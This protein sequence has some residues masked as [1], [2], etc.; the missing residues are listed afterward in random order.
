[1]VSRSFL[2]FRKYVTKTS[3]KI[4]VFSFYLSVLNLLP[5]GKNWFKKPHRILDP[6]HQ[7]PAVFSEALSL[8]QTL[9]MDFSTSLGRVGYIV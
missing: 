1:M 3:L 8:P 4:F 6:G 9:K 7:F 2:E 5:N